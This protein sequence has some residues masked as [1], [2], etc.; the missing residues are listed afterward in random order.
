M[1]KIEMG[2]SVLLEDGKEYLCF[3]RII[4]DDNDYV[5]LV[6]NFKPVEVKFAIQYIKNNEVELKIIGN[7][8]EKKKIYELFQQRMGN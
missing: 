6:S 2:E 1:N 4:E 7:K 8:E 3:S 5:Y